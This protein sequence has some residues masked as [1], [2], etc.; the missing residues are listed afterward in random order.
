MR[1]A[2]ARPED[3]DLRTDRLSPI[4]LDLWGGRD[5]II[6]E[7][8]KWMSLESRANWDRETGGFLY[9]RRTTEALEVSRAASSGHGTRR[10]AHQVGLDSDYGR[11]LERSMARGLQLVGDYH[12]HTSADGRP[13]PGDVRGWFRS[14][15][16]LADK[17]D[18]PLPWLPDNQTR[19][20]CWLG[21]I[22][23]RGSFGFPKLT[24]W[25]TRWETDRVVCEPGGVWAS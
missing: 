6:A 9:G 2:R 4:A 11:S 20:D 18:A 5:T 24:T 14:L 7:T 25:I 23:S 22:V 21:V 15:Q 13:S 16:Y 19:L 3:I 10:S 1:L 8:G 12:S 17:S